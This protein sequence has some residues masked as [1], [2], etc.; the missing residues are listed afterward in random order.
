ML[1]FLM[2]NVILHFFRTFSVKVNPVKWNVIIVIAAPLSILKT[3]I[4]TDIF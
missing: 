3:L 2:E 1:E 4:T